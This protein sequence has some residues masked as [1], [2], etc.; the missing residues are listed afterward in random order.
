M[1]KLKEVHRE[2]LIDSLQLICDYKARALRKQSWETFE[3]EYLT[4]AIEQINANEFKVNNDKKNYFLWHLDNLCWSRQ[5]I[6]GVPH[7]DGLPLIDTKLG[8]QVAE[9]C[10]IA[11]KGQSFYDQYYSTNEFANLFA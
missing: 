9:V 6:D 11:S 10:R 3:T 5:L 1:V 7:K 2:L 4:T 8:Q